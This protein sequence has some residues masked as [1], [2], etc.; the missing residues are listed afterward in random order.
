M[1]TM[2]FGLPKFDVF[3]WDERKRQ[4]N[5]ERHGIDFRDI[6]R[7]F[8]GLVVVERSDRKGEIR[9]IG[10]GVLDERVISVIFTQRNETCRIISARRA[11]RKERA[12]YRALYA[13]GT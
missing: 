13:G 2:D 5:L 12:A 9:W 8:E 11:R 1:Q 3:E 10:I 4:E 7:V 6:F